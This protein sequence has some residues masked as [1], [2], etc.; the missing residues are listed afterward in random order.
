M[1]IILLF[2]PCLIACLFC[3]INATQKDRNLPQRILVWT[4]LD[5][6]LYFLCDA[7]ISFPYTDVYTYVWACICC[8]FSVPLLPFL[9]CFLFWSLH[10][11][12]QRY[13]R[14]NLFFFLIPA[15]M[16]FAMLIVYSLLGFEAAADFIAS[17]YTIP[18]GVNDMEKWLFGLFNFVAFD[19]YSFVVLCSISVLFAYIIYLVYVTDLTPR[20][21]ARFLFHSGPIR[22]IHLEMLLIVLIVSISAFRLGFNRSDVLNNQ[23]MLSIMFC[24]QGIL[25][26][27]FGFV[28]LKMKKTCLYWNRRHNQEFFDDMPADIYDAYIHRRELTEA[29]DV[30]SDSYRT[31]NLRDEF[32][33]VMREQQCYL[34][35]GMSRYV[36]SHTLDVNR[37]AIDRL[38]R[39]LYHIT[40]EEYVMVQRVEYYRRYRKLYPDEPQTTI[41]M[42]CGFPNVTEMNSQLKECRIFFMQNEKEHNKAESDF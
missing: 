8:G 30:E 5:A 35:P 34:M 13:N 37:T 27:L 42:E 14:A 19:V 4:S 12:K 21:I 41:A 29:D 38:V 36:I 40:Y 25:I 28:G 33:E 16:G 32:K 7:L 17:D 26:A 22:P 1:E 24:L 15:S 2:I 6:A 31:L 23:V 3:G 10:T 20:V 39:L 18:Y 9:L 11:N